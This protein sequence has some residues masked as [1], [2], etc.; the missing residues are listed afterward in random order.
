MDTE[1]VNKLIAEFMAERR[2]FQAHVVRLMERQSDLE[3]MTEELK[4]GN[5][6]LRAGNAELRAGNTELKSRSGELETLTK[7][8]AENN[9]RLSRIIEIH[10]YNIDELDARLTRLEQRRGLQ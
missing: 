8:V 2:E 10:D 6:E 9:I 3:A 5:A 7:Q 1:D 4:A